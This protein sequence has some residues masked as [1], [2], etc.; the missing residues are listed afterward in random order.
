M[1]TNP[2]PNF[3]NAASPMIRDRGLAHKFGINNFKSNFLKINISLF[4]LKY[5][6]SN[7]C[8]ALMPSFLS[9]GLKRGPAS[10]A[11]SNL[12]VPC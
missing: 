12:G 3:G 9:S 10:F 8:G 6:G 5:G 4:N 2:N 1:E 11:N 7:F